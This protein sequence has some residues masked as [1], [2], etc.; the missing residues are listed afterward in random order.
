MVSPSTRLL[1][2]WA[3]LWSAL[4]AALLFLP[5]CSTRD[6]SQSIPTALQVP[7]GNALKVR[8]HAVGVQVYS[9]SATAAHWG[10]GTPHALLYLG[11]AVAAI[12]YEGPTW[13][14][15][16]GSSVVG[17]KVAAATVGAGTIPWLLLKAVKTDGSGVFADVTYVQRLETSGGLAPAGPGTK[18]GEQILV[19][20][21][22][23]YVF[24]HAP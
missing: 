14:N 13:K 15:D 9:W 21:E 4:L 3:V 11:N 20:Y 22:A 24:F 8:Y 18:D 5:A 2:S 12:H 19:P 6:D 7:A 17:T 10:P 16:D 1:N 23:V